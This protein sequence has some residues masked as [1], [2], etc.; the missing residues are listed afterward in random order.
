MYSKRRRLCLGA[1]FIL[2]I[3]HA[4]MAYED[5]CNEYNKFPILVG[6][7]N[8]DYSFIDSAYNQ[9]TESLAVHS[10]PW[11]IDEDQDGYRDSSLITMLRGPDLDLLWSKH[12]LDFFVF[13]SHL[14]F[15]EDGKYLGVVA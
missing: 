9:A 10:L 13:I 15:S 3:G 2:S 12:F 6:G 8:V 7:R 5:V 4:V 1:S 11:Y 14:T